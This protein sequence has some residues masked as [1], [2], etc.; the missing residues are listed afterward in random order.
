MSEVVCQRV[1]EDGLWRSAGTVL[2]YYP[3]GDEVD[4]RPL[5]RHA[6]LMNKRVLLPVVVGDDLELRIYDGEQSMRVGAYGILEPTGEVFPQERYDEINVAIVPGMAF[7][8][9]GHRLGR[10]KGYYDRLLPR[11]RMA[12]KIGVCWKFQYINN[13]EHEEHDVRMD[14]VVL[15]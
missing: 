12:Y 3:L 14:E 15:N 8:T 10:G 11:L 2:L 1:R 7:D 4:V 6:Q 5:I 9:Y 13:V